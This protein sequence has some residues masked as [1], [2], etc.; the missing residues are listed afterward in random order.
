MPPGIHLTLR[1]ALVVSLT[2]LVPCLVNGRRI[3]KR[4]ITHHLSTT[5][6]MFP[7]DRPRDVNESRTVGIRKRLRGVFVT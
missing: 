6:V 4:P 7:T 1:R 5:R 2:G 3:G